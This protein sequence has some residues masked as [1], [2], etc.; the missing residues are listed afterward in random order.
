[1]T[2]IS[3]DERAR[4][5]RQLLLPHLGEQ[6]QERLRRG[7]ALVVGAGGLGSPALSYLVAAGLG[8]IGLIDDDV[9]QLSNLQ[10]QVL[11]TTRDVGLPKAERAAE[12]LAAVNPHVRLE[13]RAER[14]TAVNAGQFVSDYD[15]VVSAVDNLTARYL[16][17][18]ACVRSRTTLVE[19]AVSGLLGTAITIAG[20]ETA[21]YRCLFPEPPPAAATE[22]QLLGVMGPVPGVIGAIQALEVIKVLA[23]VGR[24]LHDRLLHFDGETMTFDEIAVRR[25]PACP[26]CGQGTTTPGSDR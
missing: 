2:T 15:V 11:Y 21:C 9:V 20:G 10:R 13:P 5:E 12:R 14:L 24:P 18:D 22:G 1:M 17:N 6:G 4:Y 19:G 26:A 3:A 25:S 8:R 23:G 7:S 16:L